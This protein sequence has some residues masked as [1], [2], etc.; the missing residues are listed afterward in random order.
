MKIK[1][2]KPEE[3]KAGLAW[4]KYKKFYLSWGEELAVDHNSPETA[5]GYFLKVDYKYSDN[6]KATPILVVGFLAPAWK[7]IAKEELKKNKKMVSVGKAYIEGVEEGDSTICLIVSKGTSKAP[8]LKQL[9]KALKNKYNF[10]FVS[11]DGSELGAEENAVVVQAPEVQEEENAVEQKAINA[12]VK[13]AYEQLQAGVMDSK[14]ELKQK[15][16]TNLKQFVE[17]FRKKFADLPEEYTTASKYY[18]EVYDFVSNLHVEKTPVELFSAG[19]FK[20]IG[21]S[22]GWGWSDQ[23]KN[24]CKALEEYEKVK[25]D[26][27]AGPALLKRLIANM[28]AWEQRFPAAGRGSTERKQASAIDKLR[29]QINAGN[30]QLGDSDMEKAAAQGTKM[31][32]ERAGSAASSERAAEM[33]NSSVDE[34]ARKL[35]ELLK[36]GKAS[37]SDTLF[38]AVTLWL[39]DSDDFALDQEY[40]KAVVEVFGHN[41]LGILP[42]LQNV[43]GAE[44]LQFLYLKQHYQDSVSNFVRPAMAL[45]LL[46]N[47]W[48]SKEVG[49]AFAYMNSALS[50][51][52]I[53][54]ILDINKAKS[55][56]FALAIN[57]KIGGK[58]KYRAQMQALSL[59]KREDDVSQELQTINNTTGKS[60][61]SK[62]DYYLMASFNRLGNDFEG[63]KKVINEWLENSTSEEREA[64]LNG[65]SE[66]SKALKDSAD[67][68]FTG[69]KDSEAAYLR[70][71]I[72]FH[73]EPVQGQE[74]TR[75]IDQMK[76]LAK[77]QAQKGSYSK[78]KQNKEMGQKM[79][80]LL[81]GENVES[82][83][84]TLIMKFC[85]AT[86]LA[87]FTNPNTDPNR[88]AAILNKAKKH[89]IPILNEAAIHDDYMVKILDMVDSDGARGDNYRQLEKLTDS[90]FF[91]AEKAM[92]VIKDL[93]PDSKEI[94][95]IKQDIGMLQRLKQ[96]ALNGTFKGETE[97]AEWKVAMAKL[98]LPPAP[99]LIE[100]ARKAGD[101]EL[102]DLLEWQTKI[103]N[104]EIEATDTD[105][106]TAEMISKPKRH[107]MMTK[108]EIKL[109]QA[110][111]EKRKETP[112]YWA[113]RMA[114]EHKS[115]TSKAMLANIAYEARNSGIDMQ[116]VLAELDKLGYTISKEVDA[117]T[118]QIFHGEKPSV[119]DMLKHSRDDTF[120]QRRVPLEDI[121]ALTEGVD[122][123]V[124]LKDWFDIPKLKGQIASKKELV[125]KIRAL[126]DKAPQTAEDVA[127]I[128][129]LEKQLQQVAAQIR[130]FDIKKD[131]QLQLDQ[132][133][134][135]DKIADFK[136]G[137]REQIAAALQ[138]PAQLDDIRGVLG[139]AGLSD[140][141]I[142]ML[143][144]DI[145]AISTVE[146]QRQLQE[147]I[148]WSS[149][150]SRSQ[151]KEHEG[152][153]F[154]KEGWKGR[155]KLDGLAT[156][157]PEVLAEEQEKYSGNL[158]DA[159]EKLEAA[160]ERFLETKEKYD[161][162]L[163]MVVSIVAGAILM[164][165]SS[166]AGI[167]AAPVLMQMLWAITSTAITTVIN[168]AVEMAVKGNNYGG[169]SEFVAQFLANQ[170][171]NM[172]TFWAGAA[173]DAIDL[174]GLLTNLE[175]G[176]TGGD[177]DTLF[178]NPL[179]EILLGAPSDM[180]DV[181]AD[182]ITTSIFHE[183][184]NPVTSTTAE[185]QA[186]GKDFF[187]SMPATYLKGVLA[188]GAGQLKDGALDLIFGED[189]SSNFSFDDAWGEDEDEGT[190]TYL[191]AA[192]N[193]SQFFSAM[194]ANM[195]NPQ[196]Y[197]NI[198]NGILEGEADENL[199][200]SL[201]TKIDEFVSKK[202]EKLNN[203][204]LPEDV[205]LP[206]PEEVK[207]E[208]LASLKEAQANFKENMTK[209][210][211]K[212]SADEL[213]A[214]GLAPGQDLSSLSLGQLLSMSNKLPQPYESTDAVRTAMA[215][216]IDI[217]T[218]IWAG[219]SAWMEKDNKTYAIEEYVQLYQT[220]KLCLADANFLSDVVTGKI[221]GQ[222]TLDYGDG[223]TELM[224]LGDTYHLS[225][226]SDYYENWQQLPENAKA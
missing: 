191:I 114:E 14:P 19:D 200:I 194:A 143:G 161:G 184:T 70:S 66:F 135:G 25:N 221:W 139:K 115:D 131:I 224:N 49:D 69:L 24:I 164:A 211:A 123:T 2:I 84:E 179:K 198:A 121:E 18:D 152:A 127:K 213:A 215:T 137:L 108:A 65:N 168:E 173:L 4:P 210:L 190:D 60:Y 226:I 104:P 71:L 174:K 223:D 150:S 159:S 56:R 40:R 196:V 192:E 141:E 111:E 151:Q 67:G 10:K 45:G 118:Y 39:V 212:K 50:S 57:Q 186:W 205:E 6:P 181:I 147:G 145:K 93:D 103:A 53:D 95:A 134:S 30:S 81:F 167:P 177:K 206:D 107:K 86:E 160:Q 129:A 163:R 41:S 189:A 193:P 94:V 34:R 158:A 172:M 157:D 185:L 79:Q 217:E 122:T 72:E 178:L 165:V 3:F 89:L 133:A 87:E 23:Y 33:L 128:E 153:N 35:A 162:R 78:W 83:Q 204:D 195:K 63:L 176:I 28:D 155:E 125:E 197:I 140:A 105:S 208:M 132:T 27:I 116:E 44:S 58:D 75:V 73:S 201:G 11:A 109:A 68:L 48:F 148:Q 222:Y 110:E 209:E 99:S 130:A 85:T 175:K 29:E 52:E 61:T 126:Q 55:D 154:L 218:S 31:F 171:A 149:L 74:S 180:A 96:N 62:G 12:K 77:Q 112:M 88:K 106:T 214:M 207:T 47:G 16:V 144:A 225:D 101:Q 21:G 7:K 36:G 219:F 102:V 9:K 119:V 32:E 22:P 1:K 38:S 8:I 142:Q 76:Q 187:L 136:K 15:V 91:V 138:D 183:K 166:M 169:A 100:E 42:D 146:Y 182:S 20:S 98:G 5:T 199:D 46:G 124:L 203:L 156:A 92:K 17:N 97:K 120:L 113:A 64:V 202:M 13:Q 43:F 90:N 37:S 51:A 82:P 220:A 117:L 54:T 80:D 216:Y 170:T 188:E 26:P 59:L